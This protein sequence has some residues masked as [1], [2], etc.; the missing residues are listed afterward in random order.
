[1]GAVVDISEVLAADREA[2]KVL[3][4]VPEKMKRIL[5]QKAAIERKTHVY[6]NITFRLENSTFALGPLP[7]VT[8]GAHVEFGARMEY[9]SFVDARGRTRIRDLAA[10]GESDIEFLFDADA[11]ALSRL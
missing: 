10:E 8:D 7:D 4:S 11:D 9:A 6:N 1:M 2:R 5:D 3:G